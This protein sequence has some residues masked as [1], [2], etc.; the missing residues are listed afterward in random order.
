MQ[1]NFKQRGM[2][3]WGLLFMGLL[4]IFFAL[5]FFKLLP[6]YMEYGTVKTTLENVAKQ[7]DI[8]NMEKAEIKNAIQR[9]FDI[10]DIKRVDLS[11]HLFV[12][13]KPGATTI[14]LAY[15]VRVPLVYNVTALL[16]FEASKTVSAR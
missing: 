10:E 13:K 3:M 14:R 1:T 7:P 15:E 5:L 2:T 16:D 6:P 8:G 11:K 4:F 12:E 9:R